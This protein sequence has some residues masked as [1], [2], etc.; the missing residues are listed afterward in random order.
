MCNFMQKFSY[1]KLICPACFERCFRRFRLG[2]VHCLHLA[3]KYGTTKPLYIVFVEKKVMLHLCIYIFPLFDLWIWYAFHYIS[4][5][6]FF[7]YSN[8]ITWSRYSTILS[9]RLRFSRKLLNIS[10][11]IERH[12]VVLACLLF[13]CTSL[14]GS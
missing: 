1:D 4:H 13:W 7:C 6:S 9:F 12:S 14:I 11:V 8:K 2:H 10:N 3:T 5:P